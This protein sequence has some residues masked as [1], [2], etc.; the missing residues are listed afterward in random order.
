M[1]PESK[2]QPTAP[3]VERRHP[4]ISKA[5]GLDLSLPKGR[6]DRWQSTVFTAPVPET[7]INED[8]GFVSSQND[9]GSTEILRR[10]G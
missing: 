5:V 10:V 1:F 4:P 9:V 8:D 3:S 6:P 2:Y 7:R